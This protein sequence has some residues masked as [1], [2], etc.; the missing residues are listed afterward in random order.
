M[1]RNSKV[2]EPVQTLQKSGIKIPLPAPHTK[3]NLSVAEAIAKR[4]S[5]REFAAKSLAPEEVSQL[6]WAAQGITNKEQGLRASPSAGAL[7]P[8]TVF[9]MNS[10]GL[11][12][13]EPDGHLLRKLL[14][15]DLREKLQAAALDQSCVG[16]AP[17]CLIIMMDVSVTAAKYGSHA[18]RYCLI[19]V[20]HVAQNV[21]LQATALDLA[22]VPVGAFNE[23]QVSS[24]LQL[25]K[26][27]QPVYLLPLGHPPKK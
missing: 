26:N 12:E 6:C 18:E 15:G 21:L 3:G 9:V 20:G 22:G 25:P 5:H 23:R 7:Y 13:Y 2:D 16:E 11:F 14:G 10:E 4:R 1:W 8:I 27:L 19:E 17:L 24:L